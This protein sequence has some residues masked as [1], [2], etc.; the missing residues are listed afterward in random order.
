MILNKNF[1]MNWEYVSYFA[2]S[3]MAA[4]TLLPFQILNLSCAMTGL[5]IFDQILSF[6]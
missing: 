6:I 1:M 4:S 5:G 2:E 3:A